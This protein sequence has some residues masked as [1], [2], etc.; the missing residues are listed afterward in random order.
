MVFL[1]LP[2]RRSVFTVAVT[3]PSSPGGTALVYPELTAQPH[4]PFALM[5][6]RLDLPSFLMMKVC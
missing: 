1:T 4:P 6:S 5:I 2:L 3:R